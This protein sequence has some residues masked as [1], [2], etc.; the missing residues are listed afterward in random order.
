M[1]LLLSPSKTLDYK[2]PVP[3]KEFSQPVLL[4]ESKKLI[5][6]LVK[7]DESGIAKLMDLSEK[8]AA[9][10]VERYHHFTTPFT[11]KNARQA[12]FAFKG[13]V[14]N[15]F[16]L[17]RFKAKDFAFAQQHLRIISGLYGLLKPLDLI[18][19]YRLEM[20]T[21]LKNPRGKTLYKFWG[22]TITERINE[23]LAESGGDTVINLASAE[24]FGAVNPKKLKAT[25]ITPQFKEKKGKEYKMIGLFAKRA[26][27]LMADYIIRNEI[28]DADSLKKF[29][30][31]RY[32]FT[33]SLSTASEWVFTR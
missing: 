28:T 11:P 12:L 33:H 7:Y 1:I 13:D 2:T 21:A 9:L 17:T 4:E 24:Y 31:E 5:K 3:I 19:P 23:A 6:L 29:S 20:G 18:Q 26:R 14:Y 10:N 27:G 30:S 8:L 22:D 15:G 32:H 16:D 25:L